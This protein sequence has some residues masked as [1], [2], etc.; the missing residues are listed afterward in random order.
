MSGQSLKAGSMLSYQGKE[1]RVRRAVSLSE[2]LI[3]DI[4]TRASQ[5]VDITNVLSTKEPAEKA[6]VPIELLAQDDLEEA[7]R[8]LTMI[9]PILECGRGRL[10]LVELI[11]QQNGVGMSTLRGWVRTYL[12]RGL[13]SDLAPA[14]KGCKKTKHLHKDVEALIA[15][16]IDDYYLTTQ[17]RSIRKCYVELT[18]RAKLLGLTAPSETTFRDRIEAVPERIKVERRRGKKAARDRFAVVRGHF[19]G[20]DFPLSIIQIDHTLLDIHIVDDEDRKPI[21][22]PWLTLAID[23]CT[24]MIVGYYLS[25]DHPSALSVGICLSQ[26]ANRKEADLQRLGVDGEWPVWGLGKVI[27]ADNGKD[28]RSRTL[29]WACEQHGIHI[30]WR[31]V[32]TPHYGGHIE[33]L[34]GTVA[35]EIHALPGTTFSN[36]KARGEYKSEA[37]ACMTYHE[38]EKWLVQF[39]VNVYHRRMHR[40]IVMPPIERWRRGIVG[41]GKS[42]GIGLPDPLPDPA[43]FRLDLLPYEERAVSS[44]GVV[45]DKVHY[46]S[47][48]LRPWVSAR[49]RGRSV[50]FIVRR[51]PRDISKLYFLDPELRDYLEIPYRDQTKPSISIWEYREAERFLLEQGR[52]AEDEDVIFGGWAEM[53]QIVEG[54]KTETKKVRR[55]RQRKKHHADAMASAEP[56]AQFPTAAANEG[57]YL[58]LVVDNDGSFDIPEFMTFVEEL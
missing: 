49:K 2:I 28:F 17:Q 34:L 43:R 44:D 23:V 6:A 15:K 47:E 48:A 36:I 37:K 58:N 33:R 41:H 18:A 30:E 5:V 42:V 4:K 13:L 51:D 45:W 39:F 19:P 53:R 29:K 35:K 12:D 46:Y 52:T 57:K 3:E 20:A 55:A 26:A 54:A 14:R 38:L 50:L 8:R 31:P 27:H 1:W 16:V 9:R 21:G 56:T 22:R 10:R 32:K 40:S 11:S 7:R 24:R 25:L